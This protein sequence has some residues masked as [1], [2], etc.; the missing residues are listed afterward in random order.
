MIRHLGRPPE[1]TTSDE[2]LRDHEEPFL[3]AREGKRA[4]GEEVLPFGRHPAPGGLDRSV[5]GC[6][7]ASSDAPADHGGGVVGVGG[8]PDPRVDALG[9]PVEHFIKPGRSR[10]GRDGVRAGQQV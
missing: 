5:T 7:E 1:V 8:Q 9:H 6:G 10:Q 3:G 4:E 2:H